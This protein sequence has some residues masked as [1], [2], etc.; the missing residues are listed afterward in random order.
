MGFEAIFS[1]FQKKNSLINMP[2][3]VA[4]IIS[5]GAVAVAELKLSATGFTFA[6]L[7]PLSRPASV[8]DIF[9]TA[10]AAY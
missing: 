3:T 4:C 8:D 9:A 1:N 6:L 2:I 5:H 7:V 10:V